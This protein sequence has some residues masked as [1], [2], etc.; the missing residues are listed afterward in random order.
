MR[1]IL[2][3][4]LA[5]AGCNY[6]S[7]IAKDTDNLS[8]QE[9]L[10]YSD[11]QVGRILDF[12][13]D[14]ATTYGMLDQSAGLD[15]DAAQNLVNHRDGADNLCDTQDDDLFD[16]LD[17]VD[18][19]PQVGDGTIEAVYEYLQNGGD[20]DY[21]G[22]GTYDDVAFTGAEA[23]VVL[24]IANH[25]SER[26]LNDDVGLSSTAAANIVDNRPHD[27]MDHLAATPEVGT[28]TLQALKDYIPSW[29]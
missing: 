23:R 22:G 3:V 29:E 6:E 2:L 28:A 24:D 16:S 27:T 4:L 14:C 8:A 26:E 21:D 17:E 18:D 9:R 12:L 11:A 1:H 15:S 20:P 7:Q 19:V 10:G 13:N 5:L 25:A